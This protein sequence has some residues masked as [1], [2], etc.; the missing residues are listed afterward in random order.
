[1]SLIVDN[2]PARYS[3]EVA[4]VGQMRK[5]LQEGVLDKPETP[6]LDMMNNHSK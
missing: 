1:M 3:V 6:I 4:K 2:L 5:D